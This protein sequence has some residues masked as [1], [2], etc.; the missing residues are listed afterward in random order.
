MIG[1]GQWLDMMG[2]VFEEGWQP[3]YQ[4]VHCLLPNPVLLFPRCSVTSLNLRALTELIQG[5]PCQDP[6]LESFNGSKP[7]KP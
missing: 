3:L 1:S 7:F 2:E 5:W 4:V 6:F